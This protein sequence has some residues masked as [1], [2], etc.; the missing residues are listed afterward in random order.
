[1]PLLLV[2]LGK[3]GKLSWFRPIPKSEHSTF[4][5]SSF[6]SMERCLIHNCKF[7][8]TVRA[9]PPRDESDV[10]PRVGDPSSESDW[11]YAYDFTVAAADRWSLLRVGVG[12][13]LDM[14]EKLEVDGSMDEE[15]GTLTAT[16][17][18]ASEHGVSLL[19]SIS[20][21]FK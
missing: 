13:A 4:L 7:D 1:M 21:C 10:V 9:P 2:K 14:A 8:S 18:M 3:K 17:G 11:A 5:V 16:E 19:T 15:E 6:W 20:G 12:A